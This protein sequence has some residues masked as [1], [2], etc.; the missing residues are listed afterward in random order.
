[1]DTFWLY[2][3]V[4]V[5]DSDF[6]ELRNFDMIFSLLIMFGL[7]PLAFGICLRRWQLDESKRASPS[8]NWRFTEN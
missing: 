7:A 4:T 1:V 8:H 5:Y 6:F 3:S 2:A